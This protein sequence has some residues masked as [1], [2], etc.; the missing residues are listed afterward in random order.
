MGLGNRRKRQWIRVGF[1]VYLGWLLY[2]TLLGRKA[3]YDAAGAV[4]SGWL[5]T[6]QNGVWN[7]DALGNILMFAPYTLL[8]YLGFPKAAGKRPVA[9]AMM[10][11]LIF[12]VFI[13]CTQLVTT[14]G[15]FQVADLAYNTLSGGAGA[16]VYLRVSRKASASSDD[17]EI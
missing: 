11:S 6:H 9:R 7:W 17:R 3:G 8:M 4:W 1:F 2:I 15:T 14:R 5:V 10:L 12:S 16:L 13:E